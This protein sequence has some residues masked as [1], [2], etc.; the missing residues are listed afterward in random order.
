MHTE[1]TNIATQTHIG[2]HNVMAFG[3]VTQKQTRF[4]RYLIFE[5]QALINYLI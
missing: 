4:L 5:I 3:H 2:F 1:K